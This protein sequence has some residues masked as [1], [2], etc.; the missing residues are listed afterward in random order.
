MLAAALTLAL[1]PA[2]HAAGWK[3]VTASDGAN[4]DQVSLLRTTDGTLHVAWR[5]GAPNADSLMHTTIGADGKI[6]AT[7]TV[8]SGWA[9]VQNPAI[10]NAPGGIRMFWGSI[11]STEPTET[12]DAMSTA[13]SPDGGAT[14]VLQEGNVVQ[15]NA[16]AYASPTTA[17]TLPDGTPLQTWYGTLGVWVHSGLTPVTQNFNL[18]TPLGSYGYLPGIA[19]DAGRPVVAWY[20]NANGHLGVYAQDV[21]SDG[22]PIGGPVNMPGTSDMQIGQTGRTP[23]AARAGGGSFVAYAT[24]YPALTRIRVWR[25]GAPTSTL[26]GKAVGGASATVATDANGRVWVVWED[27]HSA[28]PLVFARRSN[29]TGTAWGATVAVG[30][31]KGSISAY[32]VDAS[33]IGGSALDVFGSFALNSGTPLATYTRRILPGLTLLAAGTPRR[34]KA[35]KVKFTVLDAGDPVKGAKVTAGGASGRSGG[36][37]KVTL[38]VHAGR[39]L[40]AHAAAPGY[41]KASRRLVVKR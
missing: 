30:R 33:A 26:V 11:R 19:V 1:A 25:V 12:N 5:H 22:S 14:W 13:L 6:G 15:D 35:S 37:G 29:R 40:T 39:H 23:I 28:D 7:S 18:Q 21:A 17:A 16:Q 10:V 27:D 8:V 41:A 24:G 38:T 34:G 3:Q 4:T 31:P 20:S 36:N 9:D 2:A 32:D